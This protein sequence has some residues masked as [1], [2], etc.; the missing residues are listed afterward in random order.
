MI[1]YY[2]VKFLGKNGK[3]RELVD[4]KKKFTIGKEYTVSRIDIHSW[5]TDVYFHG[6]LNPY[7]SVMF[8][9]VKG[10]TV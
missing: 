4:A 6:D 7:N 1:A 8:E 5:H 2:R 9:G 3:D 10:Y